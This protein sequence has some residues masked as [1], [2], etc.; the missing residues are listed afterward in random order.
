[1]QKVSF[2]SKPSPYVRPLKGTVDQ[3]REIVQFQQLKKS[4][5]QKNVQEPLQI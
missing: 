2:E 5:F 3:S 1:M 4:E